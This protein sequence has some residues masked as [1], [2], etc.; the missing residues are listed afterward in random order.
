MKGFTV[1][2]LW[3]CIEICPS[4]ILSIFKE[5][6]NWSK[7]IAAKPD[8]KKKIRSFSDRKKIAL[9]SW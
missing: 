3:F 8:I 1:L 7:K 5:A 9:L 6:K 2:F 4:I